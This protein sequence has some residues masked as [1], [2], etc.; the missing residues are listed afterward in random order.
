MKQRIK[1]IICGAMA[2]TMLFATACGGGTTPTEPGDKTPG[3]SDKVV[4]NLC[5][6]ANL[7][8]INIYNNISSPSYSFAEMMY[9]SLL[10]TDHMGNEVPSICESYTVSDD[11]KTVTM[12]IADDVVFQDGSVCDA[13]DV[14]ATMNFIIDN[15]DTSA[16]GSFNW[17]VLESS[18]MKDDKTVVLT[19]EDSMSTLDISMAYTYILSADDIENHGAEMFTQKIFNGTGPW[20]FVEWVDGQ[21]SKF[22]RN[23]DYWQG[24]KS[25]IDELYVWYISESNAQIAS[26]TSKQIDY[27]NAVSF[28]LL[29]MLDPVKD[30][31]TQNTQLSEVMYYLQFKM[32]G[33]AP[34]SDENLRYAIM[35]S[36]D[37]EMLLD[38]MGGGQVISDFYTANC[39]GHNDDIEAIS[40][41]PELA[42]EY[43]AKSDYN[44]ETIEF[45]SR[46]DLVAVEAVVTAIADYMTQIGITVKIN[47][48]DGAGFNTIRSDGTYDI[49]M[50]NLG[51]YDGNPLTQYLVPRIVQDCHSHGYVNEDL[52]ELIMDAYSDF[53]EETRVATLEEI[54]GIMYE[55]QGPIVPIFQYN[56]YTCVRN[57][58]LG[59]NETN[60]AGTYYR[61]VSVDTAIWG[62]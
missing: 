55:M 24:Q 13:T 21:Y 45:Y 12:I 8:N 32:D 15:I 38:L 33:T 7:S 20:K 41:D 2:S 62:K 51:T 59:L 9:D 35:H 22:T 43:L 56:K 23:D 47:I 16:L 4:V 25:N 17:S 48:V 29:P 61:D 14:N 60:C 44:G 5:D 11:G 6:N 34:T 54:G 30:V 10:Q 31:S 58:L 37:R 1:R 53:N 52:N 19:L 50:V 28:D 49:F 39:P 57:G 18:E 40:Y 26:F 46:N 42:K 36:I 27:I 3:G